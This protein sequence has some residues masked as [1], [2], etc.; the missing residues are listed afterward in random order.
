[1]EHRKQDL[2]GK[3]FRRHS[4]LDGARFIE[5]DLRCAQFQGV[6]ANRSDFTGSDLEGA[7]FQDAS[8][9]GAIFTD[10]HNLSTE[11]LGGA[12]L[13]GAKLPDGLKGFEGL[14]G[15]AEASKY[16]QSLF[17][18]I[19]ALSAFSALTIFST[20]DE[21]LILWK[22]PHGT[23]LPFIHAAVAPRHFGWIAPLIILT[24]FVYMVTY[25]AE[26]WVQLSKLPAVFPDGSPL[27]RRAYPLS[28]NC[29][30]RKYFMR[31][32]QTPPI[33]YEMVIAYIFMF[34]ITLI[35]LFFFWFSYLKLH[36][37][38]I[39]VVQAFMFSWAFQLTL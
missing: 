17:K 9:R 8:L 5:C 14:K 16:L 21:L 29:L 13:T 4:A 36:H 34:G 35:T 30:I 37:L 33:Y 24:L 22:A 38:G 19:L 11:A 15:V 12:D 26:T 20:P 31:L 32:H 7:Q 28:L 10:T 27:D 18:I 39:S 2:N 1:M 23:T 6:S 3:N 25:L